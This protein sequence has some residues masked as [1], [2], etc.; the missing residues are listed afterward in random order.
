M[1]KEILPIGTVVILKNNE[2]VMISGY[3]YM[4]NNKLYEYI[5]CSPKYGMTKNVKCFNYNA[6]EDII[7]MG[8]QTR[9]NDIYNIITNEENKLIKNNASQEEAYLAINVAVL[10]E[11]EK[12]E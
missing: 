3:N 8:Y 4:N 11:M 12:N 10:E 6:I 1:K 7:F 2:S 5:G 9:E